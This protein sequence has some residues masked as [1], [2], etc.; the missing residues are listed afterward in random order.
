M[1]MS[2]SNGIIGRNISIW[3]WGR[4]FGPTVFMLSASVAAPAAARDF[5]PDLSSLRVRDQVEN[6][7]HKMTL[8]EKIRLIEASTNGLY[9]RAIKRL[10]I[11]AI[12]LSDSTMGIQEFGPSTAYPAAVAW[13]AS[14]DPKQAYEEG[15]SI[16]R[17]ARA[18]GIN[19]VIG[20]GMDIV[21]EPQCG[22]NSEYLGEDPFLAG[23][24]AVAW[25]HGL[26][27]E[28]VAA[29]AKHY[30][31]N[32]QETGRSGINC[33]IPMR[34]LREIYLPP[35][36]AAVKHG[37]MS[38]MCAYNKVNDQFTSANDFLLNY[39][40]RRRWGFK[41]FVISDYGATHS[42]LGALNA[43]LDLE[44]PGGT[45]YTV[46]KILPLLKNRKVTM[47]TIN[48]HVRRILRV[49]VA[50]RFLHR[51]QKDASIPLNDPRSRAAAQRVEA[52]GAVLL[53]NRGHI[54]PLNAGNIHTIVVTG[55]M[56]VFVPTGDG[57]SSH[58][59]P[60]I[61]PV[62]MVDAVRAIVGPR[63]RV[64]HVP[65]RGKLST[66]WGLGRVMTSQ[67]KPGWEGQYFNNPQLANKPLFTRIDT[68]IAFN[69]PSSFEAPRIVGGSFSVRWDGRIKPYKTGDYAFVCASD[70]GSRLFINGK[71]VIDLWHPQSL[72][73]TNPSGYFIRG[74][75]NGMPFPYSERM[76]VER[77]RAG[78]T[79]RLKLEYRWISG[80]NGPFP[81]MGF[82]WG[83]AR[84]LSMTPQD[85]RK[86]K[87][88]DAVI[89]CVGFGL[90]RE[91]ENWDRTYRLPG[92]QGRFLRD[93]SKL[94]PHTIVVLNAGADVAMSDWIHRVPGLLDAWY[95]GENGN[96][97]VAGIIFGDI[98]PSGRL[99]D[100]FAK[101][102]KDCPAYGHFPGHDGAVHFAEG[103]YV[104]YR[105]F[106]KKHIQPRFPFGYGLSYTT[107]G[108]RHL[109]F[110]STGTG[111]DRIITTR[112]TVTNTGKVAGAEVVQ[113]YIHPPQVGPVGRCVQTLKGFS[114]VN[115]KPGQSKTV[116]MILN[117]RDFAC[118]NTKADHWEVPAGNYEIAVGSSSR[119]EPLSQMVQW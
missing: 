106:D 47:A 55:P 49:L 84:D 102:W 15:R 85:R 61:K 23:K 95:P 90:N 2:R 39:M 79:Y 65:F 117:W 114:R 41:G 43:G 32:E 20:P 17:D 60:I 96:A 8:A 19:L 35:F 98:D 64:L 3:R 44:E 11:P 4:W 25:I 6:I 5:H 46:K 74:A 66:F 72:I 40:L 67:G 10:K 54:L 76:I 116:T 83:P 29:E 97:S 45:F 71:K 26:Q 30:A 34:A 115:L 103:I 80:I 118:F 63:V 51:P 88:A 37:V 89:A 31:G 33:I 56:A 104:G 12:R 82:G 38:L 100:T 14:W 42:T 108:F 86:I 9:T 58:V 7:L 93:V 75:I 57:G 109:M 1:R 68:H 16:G 28:R 53:K 70:D 94:N 69:S 91:G 73:G 111:K 50:M 119:D 18:R 22:R 105:W 87:Q 27:S 107:F 77:L 13:A 101:H 110:H 99:P 59:R 62:S 48:D 52:D 78:E 81:L 92:V 21:R 112:V 24:M 113:L 36:R